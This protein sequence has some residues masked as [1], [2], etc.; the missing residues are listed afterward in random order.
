M[1]KRAW[2]AA[3]AAALALGCAGGAAAAPMTLMGLD[4][5]PGRVW[6]DN[7]FFA[8]MEARTGVAFAYRQF[9]DQA[10]Y[11]DAKQDALERGAQM[12]DVLFKAA[13]TPAEELRW[14]ESGALIDLAP[15]LEANAPN[16]SALLAAH[17]DWREAITL[18]GGKIVALPAL[19][20]P[21][22]QVCVW[23]NAAWLRALN[24][25]MPG[26]PAAFREALAAFKTGDPNQD[27][28]RDETPLL[29]I[30]PWEA[31]WLM[32]FFGLAANDYN[33]YVDPTGAVRF[34]PVEPAFAD[35][36]AYLRG[37]CADGLVNADAF[38]GTHA[39]IEADTASLEGGKIGALIAPTPYALIGADQGAAFDALPPMAYAGR[40]THRD[41][42]GPVWRGAFA[43]TRACPDPA[44]ALRWV[45]A[46]YGE[47]GAVL[48]AAGEAG[49]DYELDESGGWRFLTATSL[50]AQSIL[51]QRLIVDGGATPGIRPTAFLT[52]SADPEQ[53]RLIA[54]TA[55]VA[56]AA[57][58]PVPLCYPTEAEQ[59][60]IDALQATLGP[61]VDE[62][63][64]R[65]ATGETPLNPQTLAAFETSLHDAGADRLAALWQ[66]IVDRRGR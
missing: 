20:E 50:D 10:A 4:T 30:G 64:A 49:A 57:R 14:G 22:D 27:G 53:A 7:A 2:A 9:S 54:E 55:K 21:A 42:Q 48:T 65:F 39:L 33:L 26:T 58:L 56:A 36:L 28:R 6:A 46:L 24:L 61:L 16:L 63:I 29:L 8:R 34:A 1:R 19:S 41:F 43:V 38:R 5:L 52:Q 66:S 23:I 15:L 31:R 12:P 37:L 32:P 11:Q 25:P 44:A 18:P 60:E 62:A 45:D 17:P 47:Q 59:T 35:F 3:L 40:A 51:R 13:L